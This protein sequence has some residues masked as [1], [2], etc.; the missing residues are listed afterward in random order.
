[1]AVDMSINIDVTEN[2]EKEL[3]I[4]LPQYPGYEISNYGRVKSY[5]PQGRATTIT[6]RLPPEKGRFLKP[7]VNS[8]GYFIL[9][10]RP[11]DKPAIIQ[12]VHTLVALAFIGPQPTE[13]HQVSHKN[14]NKQNNFYRNLEWLT[15]HEHYEHELISGMRRPGW[16]KVNHPKGENHRLAILTSEQVVEAIKRVNSGESQASVARFFG[17]HRS[18]IHLIV[19]GRNWEHLKLQPSD[20]IKKDNYITDEIKTAIMK[21][22][23]GGF[24]E[25]AAVLAKRYNLTTDT[26]RRIIHE[27]R[28]K[29]ARR[30]RELANK[31][32]EQIKDI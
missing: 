13:Y 25:N 18:T 28:A 15:A 32:N 2:E 21:A 24:G 9:E 27:E 3:W 4:E 10:L 19:K 30:K 8:R 29:S 7:T 6:K 5:K 17:V 16:G 1:M 26:V 31:V 22:N 14:G 20:Y 11:I 12:S 23:Y